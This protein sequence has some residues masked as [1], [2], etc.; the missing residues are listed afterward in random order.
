MSAQEDSRPPRLVLQRGEPATVDDEPSDA[1]ETL[2][3]W[4]DRWHRVALG[5]R[6]TACGHA[7]PEKP[8]LRVAGFLKPLCVACHTGYELAFSADASR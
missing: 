5:G 3:V 4:I 1:S 2:Q 7:M 8:R 6:W